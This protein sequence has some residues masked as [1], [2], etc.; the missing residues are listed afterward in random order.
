MT[1]L[2]TS[3]DHLDH[4]RIRELCPGRQRWDT[5]SAMT[6][7]LIAN[8]KAVVQPDDHVYILGDLLMGK[9]ATSI[10]YIRELT[11]IKHLVAGNHDRM[12]YA[13]PNK[14]EERRLDWFDKYIDAGITDIHTGN[15]LVNHDVC[16]H[17]VVLSHFPYEGDST[18]DERY[19]EYRPINIGFPLLHG[20]VHDAWK[21][22]VGT[23]HDPFALQINVGVDVWGYTPVSAHA[24]SLIIDA[25]VNRQE[26]APWMVNPGI[27]PTLKVAS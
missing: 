20:H 12:S 7:G 6:E 1:D 8:W 25:H 14:T 23:Q 4:E 11:G 21:V 22:K 19:K 27:D 18:Y 5:T 2:Y 9:I 24:L 10:G 17:R 16:G 3:D 13:Y 15:M 26:F